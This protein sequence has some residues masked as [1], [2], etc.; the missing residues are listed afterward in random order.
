M[1]VLIASDLHGSRTAS[2]K[3][4]AL[5][6]KYKFKSI[7]L[8]GDVN[9]SGARNIPPVDYYPIDVCANLAKIKDKLII[10]RGNCDSRVDE[11]VLRIKFE[12]QIQLK[13]NNHNCFLTHGDLFNEDSYKY[14]DGDIF[15]YGHTHIS[16]LEKHNNHFVLNP[17]S[18]T[19][20]KSGTK[21]SYLIY[22]LD[23]ETISLFD[24]DDNLLKT[25]ELKWYF[26]IMKKE[27]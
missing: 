24:I 17:G 27:S 16:V 5:D 20:P 26:N 21:K 14:S 8:L 25:L 12:D 2:E 23:K 18:M 7:I 22:D 11:F 3:L 15:M 9:Y 19:L 10:V 4:V 1:K 6:S 13:L